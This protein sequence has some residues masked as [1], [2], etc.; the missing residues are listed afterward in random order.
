MISYLQIS[1]CTLVERVVFNSNKSVLNF[2]SSCFS[3]S[4]A[5]IN[6]LNKKK[7]KIHSIMSMSSDMFWQIVIFKTGHSFVPP[8]AFSRWNIAEIIRPDFWNSYQA[9][10]FN[11][12]L[13]VRWCRNDNKDRKGKVR[14]ESLLCFITTYL[15][16]RYKYSLFVQKV[17]FIRQFSI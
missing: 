6:C 8:V 10:K 1:P 16:S 14:K 3:P 11:P 13:I 9:R 12:A 17:H 7:R 15:P 4:V 2:T 5:F